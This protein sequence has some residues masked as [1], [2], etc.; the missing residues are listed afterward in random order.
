MNCLFCD[1]LFAVHVFIIAQEA[2]K[3]CRFYAQKAN[4]FVVF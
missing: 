1:V 3:V 2:K 4:I